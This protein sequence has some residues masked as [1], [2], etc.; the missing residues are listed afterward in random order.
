MKRIPY[1]DE[2]PTSLLSMDHLVGVRMRK[3]LHIASEAGL[4]EA[5]QGLVYEM[6]VMTSF[7]P[8]KN[9]KFMCSKLK[10]YLEFTS[11]TYQ[12]VELNKF[13][14]ILVNEN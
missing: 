3:H 1:C 2:V 4:R 13:L 12:L 10:K 14:E 6:T 7:Y 8:L 9:L 11:S 5:F